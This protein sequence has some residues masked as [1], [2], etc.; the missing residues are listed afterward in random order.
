MLDGDDPAELAP[1]FL[2][3]P[4]SG[5]T[6]GHCVL[7]HGRRF[8]FTGDHLEW[9]RDAQRLHASR[10]HCWYSWTKQTESVNKL[11][12]YTFEWVVPGHGQRVKLPPAVMQR[13]L[14][15]LVDRMRTQN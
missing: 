2:A 8:L 6:E 10:A 7:L 5:H 11:T 12:P 9:D 13:E 4:T 14:T 15:A 1:D 3:I